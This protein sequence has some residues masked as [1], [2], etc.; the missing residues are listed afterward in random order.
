MGMSEGF[1]Y[2]CQ[3]SSC[4]GKTS[5]LSRLGNLQ[6]QDLREIEIYATAGL[7]GH[8]SSGM[9]EKNR[10]GTVQCWGAGGKGPECVRAAGTLGW[11]SE[12]LGLKLACFWREGNRVLN[13]LGWSLPLSQIWIP[14]KSDPRAARV[15]Q[16]TD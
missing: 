8:L 2:T 7:G 11:S 15:C 3:H 10:R 9:W 4:P 13:V 14:F 1:L 12:A 6:H 16:N 5:S